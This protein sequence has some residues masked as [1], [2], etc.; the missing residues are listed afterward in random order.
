MQ[1]DT[2]DLAVE[3]LTG[4]ARR[5]PRGVFEKVPGSGE[6]WIRYVDAAGRYRREKAGSK[7]TAIDLVRKRKT[8]ALQGKKLPEKL[9]RATVTFAEIARDALAYSKREKRTYEDDVSRMERILGWFRERAADSITPHEIEQRLEEGSECEGW[10]ASTVNHY[11]SLMSLAYR[12]AIRN[13]KAKENPARATRHRREDNSRVRYL[14]HEEET[15]LRNVLV[16]DWPGHV[17]ELDLALHTGLRLSEMYGLTWE[18]VNLSQRLLTIPRCKNGE[19]RYVRLNSVALAALVA[20]QARGNGCGPVVR[21]SQGEPLAGPRYWF[22]RALRTACIEGFHWHDLRHTFAS[23]LV[24][25]G[26][27]LRAVQE[28]LGHKSIAMTVRYSHLSPDYQLSAVER[29][30]PVPEAAPVGPTDTTT[31]TGALSRIEP[32]PAHVH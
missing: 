15:R 24:M 8:E 16:K 13:G 20:F 19:R 9:R 12:L 4:R 17:P 2:L 25:A 3:R 23:R 6:W 14:S 31:D 27:N 11:R 32:Q 18:N 10:A 1:T 22:E 26:V 21:N 30:V 7:S 5:N 28:A 29:L